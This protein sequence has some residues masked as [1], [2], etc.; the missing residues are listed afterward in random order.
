MSKPAYLTISQDGSR[1]T[2][3]HKAKKSKHS[4][5][6]ITGATTGYGINTFKDIPENIPVIDWRTADYSS[7]FQH[8]IR[9]PKPAISDYRAT[10]VTLSEYLK[11]AASAGATITTV[12]NLI[13]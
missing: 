5:T 9:G 3:T 4:R 12:K 13:P 11:S 6:L 7:A 1:F 2:I 10:G 8:A